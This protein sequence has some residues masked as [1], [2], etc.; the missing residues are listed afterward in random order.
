LKWIKEMAS[1]DN[2]QWQ[3]QQSSR[4]HVSI[5]QLLH[6]MD[7]PMATPHPIRLKVTLL[8][9]ILRP[10]IHLPTTPGD[11]GSMME[12]SPEYISVHGYVSTSTQAFGFA[13][14]V[15]N[16]GLDTMI[17]TRCFNLS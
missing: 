1:L 7:S 10:H 5:R 9:V 15:F 3:Y 6:Q 4:C 12:L 11:F 14:L 2:N 16:N 17:N 8:P 13:H